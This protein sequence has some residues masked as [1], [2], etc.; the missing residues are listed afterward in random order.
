M[1]AIRTALT[2]NKLATINHKSNEPGKFSEGKLTQATLIAGPFDV[3]RRYKSME[4]PYVQCSYRVGDLIASKEIS[5]P[6]HLV[7]YIENGSAPAMMGA[8]GS[9]DF[10]KGSVDTSSKPRSLFWLK[11]VK[12]EVLDETGKVLPTAEFI[13]HLNLDVSP[14]FRSVVF[15]QKN[16]VPTSA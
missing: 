6:E 5:L 4:G 14:A 1:V 9:S 16:C 8:P 13:C 11:G 7:A 2:D 15:S 12:L 3:H 10:I